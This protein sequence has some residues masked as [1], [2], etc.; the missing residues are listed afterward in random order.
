MDCIFGF[1]LHIILLFRFFLRSVSHHASEGFLHTLLLQVLPARS[2]LAPSTLR[3]QKMLTTYGMHFW[4]SPSHIYFGWVLAGRYLMRPK[5]FYTHHFFKSFQVLP[6]LASTQRTQKMLTT[7]GLLFWFS[8]SHISV[9]LAGVSVLAGRYLMHAK[10]FCTRYFFFKS[11]LAFHAE[12]T[13]NSDDVR[14][15]F[16]D[17]S[18]T[19]SHI[20][21]V[22]VGLSISS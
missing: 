6:R 9:V 18:L 4:F 13:E 16:L 8:P 17:F 5:A 15:A 19:P 11:F 20:P 14:T 1:L 22:L 21:V 12:D 10:A 2:F 7:Y 3:T